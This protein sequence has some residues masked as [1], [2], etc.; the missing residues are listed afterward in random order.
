V[1]FTFR[2]L[3]IPGIVAIEPQQF[4]DERGYFLE[5]FKRSAFAANSILGAFVQDNCSYSVRG[6]LRGLH[7]Q[8]EPAAQGK[9]VS[10]TKGEIFDVAVDIRK[11]S[12][13]YAR[14]VGLRLS[15]DHGARMIYVPPGFAHGFCVLSDEAIVTYKTTAEYAAESDRGVVWNDPALGIDWPVKDPLLSAKDRRL[16]ILAEADNNFVYPGAQTG[17]G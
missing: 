6:V 9:L 5:S 11:G 10:V 17:H 12:P 8:K 1:A 2:H 14:W 13:T 4:Q 3:E 16:P 7:Y 15:S